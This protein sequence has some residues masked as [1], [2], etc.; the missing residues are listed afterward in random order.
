M[1][2]RFHFQTHFAQLQLCHTLEFLDFEAVYLQTY[3]LERSRSLKICETMLQLT[4]SQ[5]FGVRKYF[6]E[7]L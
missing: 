3:W 1:T 5:I 6:A 7:K 2:W 4:M